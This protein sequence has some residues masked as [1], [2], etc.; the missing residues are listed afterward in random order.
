[1]LF[2][3][4]GELFLS[5]DAFFDESKGYPSPGLSLGCIGSRDL[6]AG[7]CLGLEELRIAASDE[8]GAVV[9]M[10]VAEGCELSSRE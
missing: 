10:G 8:I 2:E 7:K 3:G 6:R 5:L 1:M 9:V 4:R